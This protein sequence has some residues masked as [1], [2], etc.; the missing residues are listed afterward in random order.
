M[1]PGAVLWSCA[2]LAVLPPALSAQTGFRLA[3]GAGPAALHVHSRTE[4]GQEA[5][6]GTVAGGEGVVQLGRLELDVNYLEG[7][8]EPDS[9]GPAP[10]DFVA[11]RALLGVRAMPWLALQI[12]PHVRSYVTGAGTQR[13]VFWEAHVR[14]DGSLVGSELRS[15]VDVWRVLSASVNVVESYDHGEGG[16]AGL[17][18][19]L[20]RAPLWAGLAYAVD[21]STLGG[22]LRLETLEQVRLTVG[23]GIR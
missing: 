7:R 13:W 10:R 15:Y 3:A 18:L 21:H 2:A 9:S 16:E 12:G 20:S 11:G 17:A 22:G 19:S 8:L 4:T 23:L 6:S 14:L 5:L 1:R